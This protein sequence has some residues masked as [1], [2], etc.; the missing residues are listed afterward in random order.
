M[1]IVLN[2]KE[3]LEEGQIDQT[4]YDKLLLLSKRQT[5]SL[6][7]NLL[8]GIGIVATSIGAIALAPSPYSCF[9]FGLIKHMGF[10]SSSLFDTSSTIILFGTPI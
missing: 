3:L 8:L 9:I 6:A 5:T 2:I 1:K 4:E 7:F 10:F